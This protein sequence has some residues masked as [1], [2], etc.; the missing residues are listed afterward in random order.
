MVERALVDWESFG[1]T[2]DI[3]RDFAGLYLAPAT[4]ADHEVLWEASPIATAGRI[5]TPTL[6]I[7]SESDLRCPIGQAEQ[8]IHGPSA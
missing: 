2:S 1:G 5:T 7:H 4:P 8:L 6:I 3:N